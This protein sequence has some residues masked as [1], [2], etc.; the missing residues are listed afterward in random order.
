MS[1]G[2]TTPMA[3]HLA[4]ISSLSSF[5]V[6]ASQL[7][8]AWTSAW[9]AGKQITAD[10]AIVHVTEST[11]HTL[12]APRLRI[13]GVTAWI[14]DRPGPRRPDRCGRSGEPQLT[15]LVAQHNAAIDRI[16]ARPDNRTITG[17]VGARGRRK[18]RSSRS[19]V[20]HQHAAGLTP[21]D[22]GRVYEDPILGRDVARGHA[23]GE[24]DRGIGAL[25][26][27]LRPCARVGIEVRRAVACAVEHDH[28]VVDRIVAH[29]VTVAEQEEARIGARS[30]RGP[31][32]RGRTIWRRVIEAERPGLPPARASVVD[33]LLRRDDQFVGARAPRDALICVRAAR[34]PVAVCEQALIR[35]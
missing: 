30:E 17:L 24:R 23:I 6:M 12:A 33:G 32:A 35:V 13:R 26:T 21:A 34:C 20:S 29:R 14:H 19:H 15:G 22:I 25:A 16:P 7:V 27:G 4:A 31:R 5:S 10:H 11:P 18:A 28:S 1:Y 8:E 2:R 3:I 9:A